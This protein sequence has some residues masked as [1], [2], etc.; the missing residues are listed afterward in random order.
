MK[1]IETKYRGYRFRSRLEARWA[2]FFDALGIKWEYEFQGYEFSNGVRYLPD[3]YLP[4]F[5]GGM[6]CEVKPDDGDFTK[7]YLFCEESGQ[8]IWFCE[9]T[10]KFRIYKYLV[11]MDTPS[12]F[13]K[14]GKPLGPYVKEP[15]DFY[16]IPNFSCARGEDRMFYDP[17]DLSIYIEDNDYIQAV[18]AACSAQF[19]F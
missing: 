1:P 4:T 5:N 13:G 9:G 8:S 19:E 2:V 3:F 17:C 10:P 14:D 12:A 16:G 15:Y 18:T 6:H 7:A 11:L